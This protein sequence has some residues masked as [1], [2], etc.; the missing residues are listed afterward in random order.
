[1]FRK[2]TFI[3]IILIL[4]GSLDWL[5]TTIGILFFGAVELNPLFSDMTRVNFSAF[6]ATKIS[7]TILVGVLFYQAENIYS[8]IQDKSINYLSNLRF[9]MDGAYVVTMISLIVVITNNII[10]VGKII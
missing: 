7:V 9:L 1:M 5:T 2:R 8:K 10:E 3:C 4:L 6:T